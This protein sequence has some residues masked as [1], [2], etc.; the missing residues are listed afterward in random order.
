M[1]GV[2]H[3][4]FVS[5]SANRA[6][7]TVKLT[8]SA[9]S[10]PTNFKDRAIAG[11]LSPVKLLP[12][13]CRRFPAEEVESKN[14]AAEVDPRHA[15]LSRDDVEAIW[16]S[17]KWL[18]G[19]GMHPSIG[20]CVRRRGHIVLER[21]LG[22]LSGNSP[23]DRRDAPKVP[24]RYDSLFNLFSAAK[25]VT[26][27]LAHLL[28][29]RRLLHLD[30]PIAEYFPE[31]GAN[32]KQEVTL[33]QILA[34][35]AGLPMLSNVAMNL[36]LL[37]DRERVIRLLCEQRPLSVPGRQ[38]AYHALTGGFIVDE[39]VRRLTGSDIRVFLEENVAKPMGMPSFGFGVPPEQAPLVAVN[40]FTGA[41]PLPPVSTLVQRCFGVNVREAVEISNDPR[42]LTAIIP[43]G[44]LVCTAEEG[45]RFFE[46]L[47]CGGELDGVRVFERRTVQR[48][49]AETSWLE[50]D[51]FLGFPVRYGTGFMLGGRWLSL[52]GP[53]TPRAF[54]HV[55][56]T[57]VVAWADP[58]RDLSACLMTTGKPLITPG[59]V[60]WWNVLR[61]IASRC[62]KVGPRP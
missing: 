12:S 60:M 10:G 13:H 4:C 58:E 33:R 9:R 22:H 26:A 11:M 23:D 37:A 14:V 49:V 3:A 29:D 54:G 62:A 48:A 32:G 24:I 25:A 59:Q 21:A 50:I 57:N 36:D 42:F 61:T 20:L 34:H 46:M 15:G 19:T 28:E 53:G 38:L 51:S 52:Y 6:A 56:F 43:S 45:S 30:D 31:F 16:T 55:G 18:Y 40:A 8:L 47:L 39:L 1:P 7:T 27:M 41:A 2:R 17:V 35:R 5:V 44:N